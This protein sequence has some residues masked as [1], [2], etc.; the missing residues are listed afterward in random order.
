[1]GDGVDEGLQLIDSMR[2]NTLPSRDS[3]A[4]G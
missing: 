4:T 2:Q 3:G 1:M